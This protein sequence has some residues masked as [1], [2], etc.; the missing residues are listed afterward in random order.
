[1]QTLADLSIEQ[2]LT[3]F[4]FPDTLIQH[5]VGSDCELREY[6]TNTLD[7]ELRRGHTYYE[8]TNEVENILKGKKVLLQSKLDSEEWFELD[9]PEGFTAGR[10]N[11]FYGEGIPRRRFGEHY[12]V[13]IQSFGS[14]ARYL[15]KGSSILYN[16]GDQVGTNYFSHVNYFHLATMAMIGEA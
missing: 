14:G 13:F 8:F 7:V 9:Q 4:N 5:K 11:E 15:P 3:P 6:L 12:N 16:H 1:M 2:Y 10:H